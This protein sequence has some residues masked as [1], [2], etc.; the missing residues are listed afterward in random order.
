MENHATRPEV[1]EALA[2][3]QGSS[4]RY[5]TTVKHEMF[6]VAVRTPNQDTPHVLRVSVPLDSIQGTLSSLRAAIL[7]GLLTVSGLGLLLALFF[8]GRL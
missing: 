2:N 4:L 7:L 6:Y 8:S 3:G 5:S 1:V